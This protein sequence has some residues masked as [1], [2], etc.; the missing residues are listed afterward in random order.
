MTNVFNAGTNPTHFDLGDFNRDGEI[1]IIV[2]N[3]SSNQISLL[4]GDGNGSFSLYQSYNLGF[5]PQLVKVGNFNGD[6]YLDLIIARSNSLRV[7]AGNRDLTFNEISSIPT[8]FKTEGLILADF[9]NDNI[10]DIAADFYDGSF[11]ELRVYLGQGGGSFTQSQSFPGIRSPFLTAGDID[12]SGTTDLVASQLQGFPNKFL[13]YKGNGNGTFQT[14]IEINRNTHYSAELFDFSGDGKLDLVATNGSVYLGD[15]TGNFTLFVDS[16]ISSQASTVDFGDFNSDGLPDA[17]IIN[18]SSSTAILLNGGV[19]TIPVIP[20][21][22]K[23]YFNQVNRPFEV[24][25]ADFNLDGKF[26]F[27]TTSAYNNRA[28]VFQ[29]NQQGGFDPVPANGIPLGGGGFNVSSFSVA[30]ADFNGDGKPDFAAPDSFAD[31]VDVFTNNGN[32]T[33]TLSRH[34]LSTTFQKRPQFIRTG[35]FN[36]DNKPDIIVTNASSRDYSVLVNNGMGEFTVKEGGNI[37]PDSTRSILAIGDITNDGKLDFVVG[38]PTLGDIIYLTGNGDGTFVRQPHLI[39]G[40]GA[41]GGMIL[42]DL[43][44]DSNLDLIVGGSTRI[45]VSFGVGNGGFFN[46]VTY[47]FEGSINDLD[48]ADVDLDGIDDLI[49]AGGAN[50]AI[51]FLKGIGNGVFSQPVSVNVGTSPYSI[52]IKDFNDDGKPDFLISSNIFTISIVYNDTNL[53]PCL[54]VSDAQATEGNGGM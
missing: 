53:L 2:V 22:N 10:S 52:S 54:S 13:I 17:A 24:E 30:V 50:N 3:T 21:I 34:R 41:I 43:N 27:V 4:L 49:A 33:Y 35:D 38:R 36:N 19:G 48:L 18:A 37:N 15:G 9:N 47:T 11:W 12:N 29:Q 20:I 40:V 31:E 32:G 51:L 25:T 16:G 7:F 45:I 46:P 39:S 1:D 23:N 42:K 5:S 28:F 8:P 44:G 26:D 14:P 6:N